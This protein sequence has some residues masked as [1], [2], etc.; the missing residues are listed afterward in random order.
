MEAGI[1]RRLDDQTS[2]WFGSGHCGRMDGYFAYYSLPRATNVRGRRRPGYE[3]EG[4]PALHVRWIADP[5]D[6]GRL[7][8]DRVRDHAGCAVLVRRPQQ[9]HGDPFHHQTARKK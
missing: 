1:S 7:A 6:P 3:I 4:R 8:G 9:V 5:E 2:G